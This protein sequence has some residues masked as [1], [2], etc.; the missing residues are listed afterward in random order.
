MSVKNFFFHMPNEYHS[1]PCVRM[2]NVF[3]ICYGHIPVHVSSFI[4]TVYFLP[5]QDIIYVTFYIMYMMFL[6]LSNNKQNYEVS[7]YELSRGGYICFFIKKEKKNF[8]FSRTAGILG[9][10]LSGTCPRVK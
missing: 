9:I 10:G 5:G 3:L 8:F 2:I 1:A 6:M 7:F 4:S